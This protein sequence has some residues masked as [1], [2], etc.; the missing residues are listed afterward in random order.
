M[1]FL[2]WHQGKSL[3]L[4]AATQHTTGNA[5]DKFGG[6]WGTEC[7]NTKFPLPTLLCVCK[8]TGSHNQNLP[9][10]SSITLEVYPFQ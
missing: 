8:T 9:K 10:L 1:V 6:K 2:V 4:S 5:P 7:L 3:A